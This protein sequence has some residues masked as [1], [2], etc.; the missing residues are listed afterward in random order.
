MEIKMEKSTN[1]SSFDIKELIEKVKKAVAEWAKKMQELT[2]EVMTRGQQLIISI[3]TAPKQRGS[4]T[5]YPPMP[6]EMK[7]V[8]KEFFRGLSRKLQ[9]EP[10]VVVGERFMTCTLTPI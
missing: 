4:V 2:Y 3:S 10:E 6:E 8:V 9:Y 7:P 5:R 1:E